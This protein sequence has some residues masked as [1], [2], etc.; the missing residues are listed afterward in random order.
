MAFISKFY[1]NQAKERI[2][3]FL[4][5]R[6]INSASDLDELEGE[7]FKMNSQ[8]SEMISVEKRPSNFSTESITVNYIDLERGIPLEVLINEDLGYSRVITKGRFFLS[9]Y[10]G[11]SI[12][13]RD[14]FG[15]RRQ[16]NK[17]PY[18]GILKIREELENLLST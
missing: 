18:T 10:T 17:I 16:E 7:K 5:E 14:S 3:S 12:S 2:L 1:L 9:G 11:F 8:G 6:E 4:D 15:N 13:S